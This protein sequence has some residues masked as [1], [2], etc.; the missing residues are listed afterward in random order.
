MLC[1]N[2]HRPGLVPDGVTR[3]VKG[4]G[5]LTSRR[6]VSA[7]EG[8]SVQD[9]AAGTASAPA[10][11]H[12]AQ[13]GVGPV[14]GAHRTL[15]R[16]AIRHQA[17]VGA[18]TPSSARLGAVLAAPV[19]REGSPVVV[20]LG[21]GTGAVSDQI[22]R[23]LPASARHLAVELDP[24]M[25][26]WLARNRQD[27]E[28]IEGDAADLDRLLGASGVGRVDVVVSSLPWSLFDA[29]TQQATLAAIGRAVAPGGTFTSFAYLNGLLLPGARQFRQALHECFDE[30]ITTATIWRNLPPAVVYVCRRPRVIGAP[31]PSGSDP[32]AG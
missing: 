13:R 22:A 31:P 20:E 9:A 15:W 18:V 8:D 30:V 26:A 19:P 23:R 12:A 1:G 7:F 11:P 16:R 10:A 28:V 6:S 14:R 17:R 32:G 3:P 2:L 5:D 24:V 25:A 4:A 21:P 27:I 29:P